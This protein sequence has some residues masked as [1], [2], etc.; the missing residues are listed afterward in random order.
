MDF[1]VTNFTFLQLTRQESPVSGRRSQNEIQGI[2][3][4]PAAIG[5]ARP[6]ILTQ[7]LQGGSAAVGF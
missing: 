4:N 6:A 7:L 1:I 2:G 3:H 5:R